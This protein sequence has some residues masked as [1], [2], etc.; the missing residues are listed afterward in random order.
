MVTLQ[1]KAVSLYGKPIEVGQFAPIV[2]LTG[3]DFAPHKIGG[4]TGKYQLISVIPSIDGGVCQTQTRTF[5]QRD[6]F[7]C[8]CRD[9]VR[10]GGYTFCTRSILRS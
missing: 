7:T 3:K 2:Y 6:I 9:S 4:A 1:G 8:E 5:Y 10:I